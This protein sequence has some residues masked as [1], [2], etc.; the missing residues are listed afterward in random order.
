MR[1][2]KDAGADTEEADLR[3]LN[4]P[5]YDGDIEEHGFPARVLDFKAKI[6]A[7]DMLLIASPEYNYSVPGGLKNAIDWASRGGNSF[8]GKFAAICGVSIGHYGTVRMQ[9][10]LRQVLAC[11]DVIV[12]PQPQVFVP[13]AEAAFNTDGSLKDA[14]TAEA[15]KKL[16]ELT[17]IKAAAVE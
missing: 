7:S 16:I 12:L 6:E 2:A 17:I 5:V 13:Y 9:P 14:K 15:L 3:E 10:H 1:Y 4:L 8:K 11:V